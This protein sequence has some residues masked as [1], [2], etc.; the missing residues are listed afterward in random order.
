MA[1]KKKRVY[2]ETSVISYLT[3]RPSRSAMQ[4][5]QQDATKLWWREHRPLFDVFVSELV[6]EEIEQ[7]DANAVRRRQESVVMLERKPITDEAVELTDRLLRAHALPRN[8]HEDAMHVA[9]ATVHEMDILLTWNCRHIANV[10]VEP[11]IMAT[12]IEANYKPPRITTPEKMLKAPIG[13]WR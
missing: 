7:G 8:A 13:E 5:A 4:A 1:V 3:A 10:V 12:I 2:L 9:L 11:R 6:D